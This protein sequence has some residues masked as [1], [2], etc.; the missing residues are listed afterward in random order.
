MGPALVR[1]PARPSRCRR[2]RPRCAARRRAPPPARPRPDTAPA[3]VTSASTKAAR[4]RA[5]PPAP[6]PSRRSRSAIVDPGAGLGQRPR[7][8]LAEPGGPARNQRSRSLDPH[9][10]AS[11]STNGG[12]STQSVENR[13][14]SIS[15]AGD[16]TSVGFSD[17]HR[18]DGKLQGSDCGTSRRGA[19]TDPGADR[20]AR[21]RAAQPRLLAAAQPAGLGPRPHRQLRGAL[22]GADDRRPRAA[23]RRPR[24]LLRRDREPAQDPRRAADPARRRAARLPG[25]RARAHPRGARRGRPRRRRRGPAAAR[26]LRLRDAARPRAPAQ[27]DDAA[28]AADGRR[29]RAGARRPSGRPRSRS[30]M[31]PRWSRGGRRARDRRPA[32]AA[33]PTTTSAPATR[34]SWPP[35]EIDRT[36]GLQ[37]RVRPLHRGDR[38][39]A[40]DVLGARRGGRVGAHRDGPRRAGRPRPPGDPRLL[41][42]RPTPSP[43]GP[44]SG[45]RPSRSGRRPTPA[46]TRSGRPGSGHL[47]TSFPTPASRPSP[48]AST[49]RSSSATSYK[50]LRGGSWATHRSV[51]R[52]SFRNW[53]LPQRR[54]IFA[55]LR[56]ARDADDRD[57]RPSRRRRRRDDGA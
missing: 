23:A 14:S 43:A 34:S 28:A 22:A 50:V 12:F 10:R 48:T 9:R 5:P 31:V 7:G 45:C 2:S 17:R 25:R 19:G 35:F 18:G 54:Q 39:R 20:A 6:R 24:P 26:R 49:P 55:G 11:L 37:R 4:R 56:C 47:R 41:G 1:R 15:P 29:L 8:R 3:S 13:R 46:C 36:S 27:R 42:R 44:A 53:D 16:P 21:R 33:S 32:R 40:A 38:R 51:V 52:P 30:P 57:R